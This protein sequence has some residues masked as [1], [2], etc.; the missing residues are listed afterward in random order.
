MAICVAATVTTRARLLP[1]PLGLM[2][3]VDEAILALGWAD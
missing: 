1:P 2:V 3:V